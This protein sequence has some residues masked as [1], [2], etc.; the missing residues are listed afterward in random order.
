MAPHSDASVT[1]IYGRRGSGKST[2]AKETFT[3]R[4]IVF[5]PQG[6]YP[7][8]VVKASDDI[9]PLAKK[10][11][12]N[13]SGFRLAWR[14]PV[15][16]D[17]AEGKDYP[18]EL[19]RLAKQVWRL[20]SGFGRDH[21]DQVTLL[22]DEANLSVPVERMAKGSRAIMEL[23]LQGRHRGI[24]LV[25]VTQRPALIS[26]DLR[27]QASEVVTFALAQPDDMMIMRKIMQS[28][29][30][31]RLASLPDHHY[32]RWTSKGEVSQ[33]KNSLAR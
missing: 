3:R 18:E 26:A 32:L 17:L 1:L 4:V 22:I 21:K 10:A 30:V 24:N 9:A 16:D 15:N 13:W 2:Y 19:H 20:Q 23:A 6:E 28:E 31:D 25:A 27:G 33:G 8:D 29:E 14:L 11:A 5:D 7:G 12:A